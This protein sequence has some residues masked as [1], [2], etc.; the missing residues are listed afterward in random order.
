MILSES[1]QPKTKEFRTLLKSW[2]PQPKACWSAGIGLGCGGG[3]RGS[4]PQDP[5]RILF[6]VNS[7]Q[8]YDIV[9]VCACLCV[10]VRLYVC[11]C[12]CVYM[13]VYTYGWVSVSASKPVNKIS[14]Y[15]WTQT[16]METWLY[17][18]C[19]HDTVSTSPN[20][21][22][23]LFHFGTI[24]RYRWDRLSSILFRDWQAC[25]VCL[26]SD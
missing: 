15:F 9:C 10:Y 21:I 13:C 23:S 20:D 5:S 2:T 14:Y 3:V 24:F 6:C 16:S 18:Y 26:H 12:V 8:L 25:W 17:L 1:Q 7:P 4:S 19:F 11:V 22:D